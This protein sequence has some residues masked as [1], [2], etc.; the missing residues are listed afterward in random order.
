MTNKHK[1]EWKAVAARVTG[2][3]VILVGILL[4][5][6]LCNATPPDNSVPSI[7]DPHSTPAESIHHLSYFVLTIT[8]VIF[9]VVFT[10]LT[11]AVVKFRRR[12]GD[13]LREPAQVY[14]STQI[15]LAWTIIPILIVVVLFLA[16][17][18]VI[19][20]IQDAPKP[21]TAVEVT[22][23]GHQFWWEFR[24]P[25]L[26]VVTANELHIPLSDPARPTPTFL[27]L[28]SADTDHSFWV[29]QLAGKTDLIPNHP[30]EMWTDPRQAGI[31]LGQCA[32]YCG[33]QHAK[34]LLRVYVDNPEE[35]AAWV[36][37]QRQ[38][39]NQD[40]KEAAGRHVF[41]TTACL[42]YRAFRTGP[43]TPDE[44]PY[45]RIRCRGK[46]SGKSAPLDREPRRH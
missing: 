32:Q 42:N 25:G 13:V 41:E 19:H 16:T 26:G 24:Y 21:A 30:N 8:G 15:E 44:P 29:P 14:G 27:K 5:A 12:A 9:L 1:T 11:Y 17:A 28:L 35:F 33:T 31:Y 7:F 22:V 37:A 39:A 18:R 36:R 4:A 10:L 45:S 38:P 3:L 6:G 43:D 23:I 2:V 34:M 40:E 46:Y 20:A